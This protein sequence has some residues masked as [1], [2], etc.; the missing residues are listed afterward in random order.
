M[1]K[2][3]A[4][5]IGN[6]G[7][8]RQNDCEAADLSGTERLMPTAPGQSLAGASGYLYTHGTGRGSRPGRR[9]RRTGGR[10]EQVARA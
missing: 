5:P 10:G 1:S 9:R 2:L 3:P 6:D 8:R 4:L 7:D